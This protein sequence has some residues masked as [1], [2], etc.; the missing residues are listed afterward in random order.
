M[1]NIPGFPEDPSIMIKNNFEYFE[2]M[3]TQVEPK[4]LCDGLHKFVQILDVQ[5]I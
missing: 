4:L 2:E 3:V 1:Y 5:L